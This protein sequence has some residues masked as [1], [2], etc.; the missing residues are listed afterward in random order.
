MVGNK[1]RSFLIFLLSFAASTL[2]AVGE[3]GPYGQYDRYQSN[4]VNPGFEN[5]KFR[6]ANAGSGTFAIT[7]MAANVGLGAASASWDA[8]ANN[9]TLTSTQVTVPSGL[10]G[11]LC[12]AE[13]I[14]KG[15]DTNI[16]AQVIDGVPAVLGS[17]VLSA[18]ANFTTG[19]INFTCPTSSTFA[20]RLLASADSAIVYLD[21]VYVGLEQT[22]T[23]AGT[24]TLTNKTLT[25]PTITS[26]TISNGTL[27]STDVLKLDDPTTAFDTTIII[28]SG[29]ALTADRTFTIFNNDSDRYIALTGDLELNGN[30][31]LNL[32]LTADSTLTLPTAGTLATRDGTE[33]LENKTFLQ[34]LVDNYLDF[35]EE[36]APATPASG[37]VR[38]YAKSD[39]LL[40]SKDDAGAETSLGGGTG[41][42]AGELSAVTGQAQNTA[43]GWAASAG[44]ITVETTTTANELPLVGI[45]SNAIKITRASGSS[46]VYY[47][48]TQPDA[49]E[50]RKLKVQWEQRALSSY[51]SGDLKLEVYK[52]SDTGTCTYS[53]GSYTE[54][55]LSTD[56]SGTTSIPAL[57]GRFVSTFDADDADCYELRIVGVAGTSPLS[58]ANVIVGPGIQPQG[59]IIQPWQSITLTYGGLGAGSGTGT[60]M[61]QRIG[62]SMKLMARFV[63][64]GTPGSGASTFYFALPTSYTLDTSSIVDSRVG[65]G[66]L[67]TT[68]AYG[69]NADA[70]SFGT[71]AA[72]IRLREIGA[73]TY[74]TG[75]DIAAG[76]EINLNVLLPIAEWSGGVIT[77]SE[78]GS[79]CV[80]NSDNSSTASNT[81]SFAYGPSGSL[82][83]NGAVGT[84]YTRRI[85][86]PTPISTTVLNDINVEVQEAGNGPWVPVIGRLGPFMSQSTNTY[87]INWAEVSGSETDIDVVFRQGGYQASNATYAGNGAPWSDLSTW[88]WRAC[89]PAPGGGTTGFNLAT[90]TGAGLVN[91]Y[92]EGSGVVYVGS[93]V[94]TI[95]NGANVAASSSTGYEAQYI[96]VG[97]R[98]TVSGRIDI[99]PTNGAPTQTNF[100]L[101]LPI[102]SDFTDE[103]DLSGVGSRLGTNAVEG[104]F[105][106]ASIANNRA[107]A[108][109]YAV[110]TASAALTFTFTYRIR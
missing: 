94:P 72:E 65:T 27:T 78:A 49:F 100:E 18:A 14:W 21:G 55:A 81:S 98:V 73:A 91:P 24:E 80:S 51:A 102:A 60:A 90:S 42:G 58:I 69:S 75:A 15:G 101:S 57:D 10:Y 8:A 46:Y 48:W 64:D 54:F 56:A 52:H 89:R 83:P 26:P 79:E 16:T 103:E 3:S 20:F 53:G 85:R 31:S 39:G 9:D 41:S 66:S 61:F 37:K 25:S 44:T 36:S 40:Y 87:G 76:T 50:N 38:L 88:R 45:S 105:M 7:T 84:A 23:I 11:Q 107:S 99:D 109:F 92:L 71:S 12:R 70:Y 86:F 13:F 62:N 68:S 28:D 74:I 19:K 67:N 93:Y 110:N 32:T 96:R 2:H 33:T 59:S 77:L 97:D 5:G 104:I 82:I 106:N 17:L 22:A 63:K 43:N 4:I 1:F 30:Q 6:W 34:D 95:T 35:N 108:V 47:R 29:A